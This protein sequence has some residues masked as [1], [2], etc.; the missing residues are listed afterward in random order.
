MR[1]AG[2]VASTAN[3]SPFHR[4]RNLAP[5]P[6]VTAK[7]LDSPS[8]VLQGESQQKL[9][10]STFTSRNILSK[11]CLLKKMP[12]LP[13]LNESPDKNLSNTSEQVSLLLSANPFKTQATAQGERKER[14]FSIKKSSIPERPASRLN[15]LS[16]ESSKDRERSASPVRIVRKSAESPSVKERGTQGLLSTPLLRTRDIR[17][18]YPAKSF[19]FKS[20]CVTQEVSIKDG[21]QLSQTVCSIKVVESI[22]SKPMLETKVLPG[23]SVKTE[24]SSEVE[25]KV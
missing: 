4:K 11:T 25:K 7:A 15:R 22:S 3:I 6:R 23:N 2:L 16:S 9:D 8:F 18:K 24:P 19:D 20:V 5:R 1:P 12:E 14:S 21:G 13:T 17:K 10:D